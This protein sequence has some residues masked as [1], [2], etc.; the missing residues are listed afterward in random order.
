MSKEN[1]RLPFDS[2]ELPAAC[3]TLTNYH[4]LENIIRRVAFTAKSISRRIRRT[5]NIVRTFSKSDDTNFVL[6]ASHH[7]RVESPNQLSRL[8]SDATF[9][10]FNSKK[11]Q[12][13]ERVVINQN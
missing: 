6:P 10:T 5:Y 4:T 9:S 13:W 8:R 11:T 12:K 7:A 3:G 2:L 1:K